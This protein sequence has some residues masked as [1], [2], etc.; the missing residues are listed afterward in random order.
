MDEVEAEGTLHHKAHLAPGQREGGGLDFWEKLS[1]LKPAE[2]TAAGSAGAIGE[3]AHDLREG[4]TCFDSL[5]GLVHENPC[6]VHR[7]LCPAAVR[8]LPLHHEVGDPDLVEGKPFDHVQTEGSLHLGALSRLQPEC[9]LFKGRVH[10]ARTKGPQVSSSAGAGTVRVGPREHSEVL[11]GVQPRDHLRESCLGCTAGPAHRRRRC[12]CTLEAHQNVARGDPSGCAIGKGG[13]AEVG[14][15]GVWTAVEDWRFRPGREEDCRGAHI[16]PFLGGNRRL[17]RWRWRLRGHRAGWLHGCLATRRPHKQCEQERHSAGSLGGHGHGRTLIRRTSRAIG[18]CM[19]WLVLLFCSLASASPTAPTD[20][21]S[22]SQLESWLDRVVV[23]VTGPAWC[24]GV[25]IDSDHVLTAYHCVATGERSRVRGRAG[26][27]WLGRT[28]AADPGEDLALVRVEGLKGAL[29][30]LVM[31]EEPLQR[32]QRVYGLGHPFGPAAEQAEPLEGLLLWSVTE[33]IVS[34]VG[35]RLV[36]TDA[37]LNPGNSGGPVVDNEGRI[38]GITSR[39]LAGDNVAFLASPAVVNAFL[40]ER[41]RMPLLGGTLGFGL[42]YLGGSVIVD[43]RQELVAQSL[44]LTGDV[45]LRER[46][47]AHLGVGLSTGARLLSFER[48]AAAFPSAEAALLLRQRIGRGVYSTTVDVGGGVAVL[49]GYTTRFDAEAGTFATLPTAG[50]LGPTVTAR[51]GVA[52]I[53]LRA[54][55]LMD[56]PARPLVLV[57]LDLDVPGVLKT[58]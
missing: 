39:K 33:G 24:S 50:L 25:V 16:I 43:H 27:E 11:P 17:H 29:E 4:L 14:R 15:S 31:V 57:G 44:M 52:G 48:G 37:A 45:V 8:T 2:V 35:P 20:A 30:P 7:P 19:F 54:V 53:G 1:A 32:G 51:L 49:G 13:V 28:V 6:L 47:V 42:S 12:S 46:L 55:A 58:F 41:P 9:C 38:V 18:H 10:H 23:L 56:D 40:A 26:Q 21:A 3:R 36:Q 22:P 5:L 34:G